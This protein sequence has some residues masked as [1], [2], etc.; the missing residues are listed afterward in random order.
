M[1]FLDGLLFL[2]GLAFLGW[3]D[4]SGTTLLRLVV[5]VPGWVVLS[6]MGRLFWDG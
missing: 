4:F 2:D 6:E 1:T 5:F 3:V